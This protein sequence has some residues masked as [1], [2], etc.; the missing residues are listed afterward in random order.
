MIGISALLILTLGSLDAVESTSLDYSDM[1]LSVVP[2]SNISD[3]TTSLDLSGNLINSV[4]DYDFANLPQLKIIKIS[5]NN[6]SSISKLAF[7]NSTSVYLLQFKNNKI[8]CLCDFSHLQ[9]P[10]TNLYL[11]NNPLEQIIAKDF[12]GFPELRLLQIKNTNQQSYPNT[13]FVA[14]TLMTLSLDQNPLG[15]ID[16]K[17]L[18]TSPN[19]NALEVAETQLTNIPDTTQLPANNTLAALAMSNNNFGPILGASDFANLNVLYVV[20]MQRTDL[21]EFPDF[22]DAKA[23]LVDVFLSQNKITV[24]NPVLLQA[25][26]KVRQIDLSYNLLR[27]ICLT[28]GIAWRRTGFTTVNLQLSLIFGPSSPGL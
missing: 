25:M 28:F 14:S 3:W 15:N 21:E 10:L 27:S 9:I 26:P 17:L 7:E 11:D 2:R 5:N 24:V 18:A 22:G 6:I 16:P 1:S 4:E 19:L 23:S 20:R 8:S 12:I 13:T